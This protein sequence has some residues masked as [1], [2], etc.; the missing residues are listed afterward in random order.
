MTA[1]NFTRPSS[2]IF[3]PWLSTYHWAPSELTYS[4]PEDG[5]FIGYQ[6]FRDVT[7]LSTSQKIAVTR[8]LDEIA[9]FTGL[10]FREITEDGFSEATMR[11][12]QE[13]GL[14]GAYAY[15]PDRGERPGDA[16]FGTGAE[17]PQ[18][19]TESY[20]YFSH[21]IGHSLGL[22][23]GHEYRAFVNSGF[24]SQEYTILT[25][26]DYDGDPDI[27]SFDSGPIDWAQ[28]YQQ[29]DIAALQYLYGANFSASGEIWSGD[30]V[31]R[32]NPKSGEMSINGVAQGSP[33]GNRIFRTIW[34]GH[35]EDTYDLSNYASDLEISLV[36]GEWSVFSTAQLA[37]LNQFSFNPDQIARGNLANARLFEGDTRALIE[38]ATGGSGDDVITGNQADNRLIGGAGNDNLAG[39]EGN[40]RLNGGNGR[41]DLDGGAGRDHLIGGNG[42]D[43]LLGQ[44]NGDRL[45]GGG[46]A[47]QIKGQNGNDRLLGGTGDDRMNAGRGADQLSGG[48]GND[49]LI[50]GPGKD[51]LTGGAGEDRF[52]F[53]RATDSSGVDADRITD[54]ERGSD[55][56]DLSLLSSMPFAFSDSGTLSGPGVTVRES[57]AHTRVIADL[58][59]DGQADLSIFVLGVQGLT[60]SDF[61]L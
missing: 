32:F 59:G 48:D 49:V 33:A 27:N 55:K 40:D 54:F 21:E 28:S 16:Y 50:G 1:V 43:L 61:L 57:G 56:I 46:G 23:H 11:F 41:D 29:L 37:D 9:S 36:P 30:T 26:S 10:S 58:D 6:S 17:I 3:D 12:A 24:D 7:A 22:N 13:N 31:Y 47:D 42:R 45:I 8:A 2:E 52:V 19:G 44:G 18:I 35:G 51:R 20:V 15:L 60:A 53:A 25:Y 34:D 14:S 5:R 4:F 39:G 38:N